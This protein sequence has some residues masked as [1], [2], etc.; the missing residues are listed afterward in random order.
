MKFLD[1]LPRK[2]RIMNTIVRRSVRTVLLSVALLAGAAGCH[3][4]TKG[5]SAI[6]E[7]AAAGTLVCDAPLVPK[8]RP[9]VTFYSARAQGEARTQIFARTA[10][11]DALVYVDA[12]PAQLI[13]VTDDGAH[14]VVRRFIAPGYTVDVAVDLS[15]NAS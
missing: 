9:E 3:P 14:G 4:E 2:N 8:D 12:E 5:A 13:R 1:P 6:V 10:T 11:G 15:K 7:V